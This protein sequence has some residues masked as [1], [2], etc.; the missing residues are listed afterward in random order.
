MG[1]VVNLRTRRKQAERKQKADKAAANR[2]LSGRAKGQKELE[3]KNRDNAQRILD[4]H[5]I[6]TGRADE[7]AGRQTFDCDR[8]TQDER[9]S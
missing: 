6:V 8:R 7:I 4:Q 5:R 2:L 3:E 1:D 9:E